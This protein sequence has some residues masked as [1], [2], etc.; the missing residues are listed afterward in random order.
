MQSTPMTEILLVAFFTLSSYYMYVYLINRQ[1]TLALLHAAFFGFA[2]TLTRYDGWFLVIIEA[3]VIAFLY[4]RERKERKRL[5]GQIILFCTLGFFG[6]GLW[7]LWNFLILGNPLYFTD[8]PFSA[9]SQQQNWLARGE[10][11]TY[12]NLLLSFEYYGATVFANIGVIAT[13]LSTLGI[14][15]YGFHRKIKEK[16]LL[17][18]VLLT[19]LIFYVVTL[20]I[21]QSLIFIP[22]V[23]PSSF[24]WN[25][26]NVR[27]GLMM[28]PVAALFISVLAL[29]KRVGWLFLFLGLIAS[30]I[31]PLYMKEIPITLADGVY[32]LSSA[33]VPDAQHW[34]SR[35][36]T[37]GIVLIDDYARTMS[38]A[39]SP[40]AMEDIIYIGN[41][42]YWEE[43]MDA[44]EKYASWII[45]QKDDALWRNIY[46]RPE[47]QGR[48][49]KYFK[50]VYT[51]P[52]IL[53]FQRNQ[54]VAL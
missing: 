14:I 52:Q 16:F 15:L 23:T 48:L 28:V 54:E 51:S 5:E 32:G 39:R 31:Y 53:I 45:M 44:P 25:L 27:Y 38:V 42:P 37:E 24:E 18:L 35:N 47:V 10:L 46:D 30:I 13:A 9:K 43:S 3:G 36:Y 7:L 50:K 8:S 29:I 33:K 34:M 17:L 2:A 49:F 22:S 11:P 19:P 4:L 12:H 20:F 1:N 41:K 40:I 26:F 21:G 6:I